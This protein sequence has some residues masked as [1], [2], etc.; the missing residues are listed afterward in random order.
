M[1]DRLALTLILAALPALLFGSVTGPARADDGVSGAALY[2]ENCEMC[3]EVGG[4]GIVEEIPPLAGNPHVEDTEYMARVIREG[5]SGAIE[6]DGQTYDEE[7]DG[8]PEL[9][10]AEVAALIEYIQAGFPAATADAAEP[11]Q[12]EVVGDLQRGEALFAGKQPLANGGPSCLACHAAGTYGHLGGSGLG[13]DLTGLPTRFAGDRG[14]TAALRKPPS[15]VM[16]PVYAGRE[17]TEQEVADLAA[18]FGTAAAGEPGESADWLLLAGV[19]GTLALFGL[20]AMFASSALRRSYS[21]MLRDS[22]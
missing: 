8:Y 10:E 5:L 11:P 4:V 7:M 2:E 20:M 19:A 21:R 15:Q 6:V 9:S 16:R 1:R 18:F 12:P 14:L 22:R 13:P 17:L 3:H